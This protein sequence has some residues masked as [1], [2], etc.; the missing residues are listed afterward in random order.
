MEN[1]TDE[2]IDNARNLLD[3]NQ[4]EKASQATSPASAM[5]KESRVLCEKLNS[6]DFDANKWLDEVSVFADNKE[7][8][9][10]YSVISDF[11]FAME[12]RDRLTTNVKQAVDAVYS[13][14]IEAYSDNTKKMVVKIYDH[15]NLAIR[16]KDMTN[17]SDGDLRAQ[18]EEVVENKSAAV[19]KDM[20][21]QL[22]SLIAIFTALSFIVFGGISSL[23]SIFQSLQSTMAEKNTVLPTLIVADLW[24]LCLMNLLFGFMYFV[25]RIAGLP[26]PVNSDAKN[27]V[28]RY[29]V[30]FFCDYVLVLLLVVLGGSWF[31]ECNGVGK[32]VFAFLVIKHGTGSFWGSVA[33]VVAVF[34]YAGWKLYSLYT[35]GNSTK[36]QK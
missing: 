10:V 9:L 33:L 28:Q 1:I 12:Q 19:T 30:V 2:K 4:G 7:N 35:C 25:L 31:A 20:T 29:P 15:I 17:K 18:I 32:G 11:V 27:L 23:D 13:G 6:V 22:V 24:G 36:T 16:Q 5:E 3:L 26:K 14:Q 8:R 21:T 34:A